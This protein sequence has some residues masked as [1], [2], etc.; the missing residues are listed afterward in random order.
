MNV[1]IYVADASHVVYAD[2]I[3]ELVYKSAL[4]RG[5]G[6][7]KR[8]PDYI[9]Q[10]MVSGKAVIALEG[11]ELAGF[12]Y[13]ET[14]SHS[15]FVANSGLIV[16]HKYRGMGLS[17]KIKTKVFNLSR[18]LYPE[19]K[20]FSIT[21]G[22]AVMKLN[23]QLGFKPVTFSELTDDVDFWKGCEG[24][25]NFDVLKR[26]NYKMCLC[27]GLLY[28]PVEKGRSKITPALVSA[29]KTLIINPLIKINSIISLKK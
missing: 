9:A 11:N 2:A 13:I 24:C 7:A 18:K 10:K 8:S 28:D 1:N 4:E 29:G 27:T 20:I 16:A 26:N 17:K 3:C 25:V 23:T 5:T 15:K 19:A 21:T 6:I 22:L 14:W 12:A